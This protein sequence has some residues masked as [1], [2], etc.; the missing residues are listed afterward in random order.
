MYR[1]AGY[2]CPVHANPAD[3]L[4]D[5]I[6]PPRSN[7]L[8][9]NTAVSLEQ[10]AAIDDAILKAQPPIEIDLSMGEDKREFQMANLALNPSWF[11]QV[12]ILFRRSIQE[13]FRQMRI[14]VTSI[15]QTIVIAILI[16]TVFL[17]IG[18]SQQ[19]ILRRE[20]SLFFCAVNQGIFGALMVINSFPVERSLSLR[21]RAS[22]T[23]FA[24]AY[25][26]AKIL[27]ETLIQF[28]VP[29]IF[30]SAVSSFLNV[31][32]VR[33]FSLALFTF[34]LAIKSRPANSSSSPCSCFCARWRRPHW[35]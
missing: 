6:T 12:A 8:F 5:V 30:V 29:I 7:P 27:A 11:K 25:F 35:H 31:S 4:L 17:K 2:P 14:I 1:I 23:Y 18:N 33:C 10:Q 28:P 24:S 26:I 13:Q 20:P 22:G 21:E 16:G 19:S 34:W 9:G 3:H 32:I 15:I